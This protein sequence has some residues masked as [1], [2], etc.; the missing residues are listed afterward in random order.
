MGEKVY[1]DLVGHMST[2]KVYEDKVIIEGRKTF[3]GFVTGKAFSGAKEI[4]FNDVTSVQYKEATGWINGFIQFD[5]P[6]SQSGD[7]NFGSENS[8]VTRKYTSDLE[9]CKKAYE[10]IKERISFYKAQKQNNNF[11]QADELRKFKQLLDEGVISNEE[12]LEKKKKILGS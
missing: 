12:F 7:D 9:A 10:F 11:S 2:M 5:Y 4:Y 6:G 1:F 3:S 8:F